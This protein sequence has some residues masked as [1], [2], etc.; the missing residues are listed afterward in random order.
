M[1]AGGGGEGIFIRP[2]GLLEGLLVAFRL[3]KPLYH[4]E[5][6][7]LHDVKV[8]FQIE[9]LFPHY[10]KAKSQIEILYLHYVK[11]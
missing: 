1:V 10:T 3:K 7:F 6:P 2:K 11:V 9:I 8:K 5:I 4:V